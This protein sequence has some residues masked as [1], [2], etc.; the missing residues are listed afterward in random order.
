MT[1]WLS[2]TQNA[3]Q[4]DYGSKMT[5]QELETIFNAVI[6][7]DCSRLEQEFLLNHPEL[8]TYLFLWFVRGWEAGNNRFIGLLQSME[9]QAISDTSAK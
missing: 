7:A 2:G 3:L 8:R 4:G 9:G 6:L 1:P 5:N